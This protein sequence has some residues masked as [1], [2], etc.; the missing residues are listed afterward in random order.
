VREGPLLSLIGKLK[1][2]GKED[3]NRSLSFAEKPSE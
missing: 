3:D 2:G 1:K